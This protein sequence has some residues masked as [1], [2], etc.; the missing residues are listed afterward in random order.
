MDAGLLARAAEAI[1]HLDPRARLDAAL[2]RLAG[3]PAGPLA[4]FDVADERAPSAGALDGSLLEAI[5]AVALGGARGAV[6][7]AAAEAALLAAIGLARVAA[8]R[9]VT[10]DEALAALLGEAPPSP[11]VTRAL[12]GAR[13]L[14]PACGGGALLAAAHGAAT[15]AGARLSLHGIDVAP[16][17]ARAA[18]GRLALLGAAPDIACA[19]ALAVAWPPCDLVLANPPFLRH[20][21]IAP[22]EKAVAAARSGLSRQA[23]LSAH[24]AA[25]ALAHAADVALVWPRALDTARSA[26]PV[27]AAAR[28]RGGFAWR[29]RSRVSGSFAASV[30]TALVAWSAGAEGR[31]PAEADVPLAA[32]PRGELVACAR[33]V[34]SARLR[35]GAAPRARGAEAI[36]LADVA[37]VRFGMKSGCN[38]FFHLA[39]KG[40]GRFASALAGEVRLTASDVAPL[41]ASLKEADAPERARP[42]RVLFRP[43]E[44]TPTARRY[45]AMGE[46]LGVAA[47]ATC[48]SRAAW[49]RVAPGRAAAPVLYPAKIGARAFAFL[50][51]DGLLEDK[52]WHAIFPREGVE[53]WVVALVLSATPVRLAIDEA[54][55]QLTGK[56]A[57]ADVDTG[58]LARAPFPSLAALARQRAALATLWSAL[59]REPVTTDLAAMLARPAQQ[60]LDAIVGEALGLAAEEVERGRRDLVARVGA[61]LEHAAAVRATLPALSRSA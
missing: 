16:L 34:S 4:A 27:L 28:A 47:R 11:P 43:A 32:L 22:A 51:G 20:E 17:A 5:A 59:G 15:R 39:P 57:I 54:S 40:G 44:D 19:D 7:T 53:P 56:Q 3:E 25:V 18:R 46:R 30:D 21:A 42:A 23:D 52:K 38:A 50:N 9:G 24:F 49:W 29:L 37:D 61:R 14:D 31:A 36:A 33:G 26:A 1:A 45:V 35:I 55:R 41:L 12:D 13:V 2:A 10:E 60:E 8:R 48:A 6:F 58:V